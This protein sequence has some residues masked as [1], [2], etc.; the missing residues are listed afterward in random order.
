MDLHEEFASV[1][2]LLGGAMMFAVQY[3]MEQ[4]LLLKVR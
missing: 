4:R 2:R 3:A 1:K